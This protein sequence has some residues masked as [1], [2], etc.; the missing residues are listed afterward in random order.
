MEPPIEPIETRAA[1][2]TRLVRRESAG[3]TRREALTGLGAGALLALGLWP[4]A[5]RAAEETPPED[6]FTFLQVNDTHHLSDDCTVWLERVVRRMREEQ[7]DFCLHVGDVSDRG[8]ERDLSAVKRVFG[9]LGAPVYAMIGNHDYTAAGDRAAYEA[10]FPDRLNYRFEHR[11]WQFVCVDSTEGTHWQHTSIP[12]G[13]LRWVDACLPHLDR[14]RPLV[15]CTHF[16]LGVGVQFRPRNADALLARFLDHNLQAVFN[17]HFHGFT[18]REF[19]GA[20]VTTDKCC[21]LKRPNHDGTLGKGFFVC[22][23]RHGRVT[24]RFVAVSPAGLPTAP[25]S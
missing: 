8:A 21:A 17:G 15:L 7:P 2:R 25:G 1:A 23:A 14:T 12:E 11:G 22:H 3:L 5:L 10:V 6:G 20:P 4:G 19:H 18:E 9:G 13:T 24:R 16:P